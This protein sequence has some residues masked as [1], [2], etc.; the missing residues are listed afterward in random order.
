ML[1]D[2]GSILSDV[3]EFISELRKNSILDSVGIDRRLANLGESIA[4]VDEARILDIMA[5]ALIPYSITWELTNSCN[6]RCLHCYCPVGANDCWS[7]SQIENTLNHLKSMG[8]IDIQIT[9]GECMSHPHFDE[10]LKLS[11]SGGF[12]L[13][14]LTNGT[15]IDSHR[16][17]LIAS[18]MPRS[19]QVSLYALD[20]AVHDSFTRV[21]GSYEKTLLG[22]EYLKSVGINPIIA[23]SVTRC[24]I[25]VID[26][27][28]NW[29]D[30]EGLEVKFNFKLISSWNPERKPFSLKCQQED[31]IKYLGDE[32]F[33]RAFKAVAKDKNRV[34]WK[35]DKLC[36]AGFRSLCLSA[37]GDVFPCNT[38]RLKLGNI[39]DSDLIKIW[40]SSDQL[41]RWREISIQEYPKCASCDARRICGPCPAEYFTKTGRID[42]IDSDTCINGKLNYQIYMN[43][44]ND[45]APK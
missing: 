28:R 13:G 8:T 18:V 33:N 7:I 36:Q 15:L 25:D 3:N 23:C 20:K 11:S 16:A 5:N 1:N 21:K 12:I 19:V 40:D 22:I 30:S 45:H 32:R 42:A 37:T 14:I 2:E 17:E 31:V 10:F 24:N 27:L 6:L 4:V 9:G 26:D 39:L 35:A 43:I 44:I 38:L 34:P 29:A 41:F